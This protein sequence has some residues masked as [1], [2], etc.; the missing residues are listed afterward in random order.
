MKLGII[1]SIFALLLSAH[2]FGQEPMA[3]VSASWRPV[4]Q[5]QQ[6]AELPASGPA[7]A[8]TNDD[9][10]FQRSVRA[11]RT[12]N[13]ENPG[14][15]TIDGRR[16]ALDKIEQQARTPS[17]RSTAGFNYSL[18]VRNNGDK[19]AKVIYWEYQFADPA[20]PTN[21]VRRQF[22]CSVNL[23][24]GGE[25]DLIAFS[26]FGPTDVVTTDTLAKQ[27]EKRFSEKTQVNRIE[28]SDDSILQR[29][30]WKLA[31]VKAGVARATATPWGK[32]I[33]RPL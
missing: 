9:K 22:L 5:K 12:D 21:I 33:C 1:S 17:P 13:P 20:T 23:K 31:D 28:Y 7:R 24:K 15:Q 6:E 8:L 18:R 27:D 10:N 4:V 32:E 29:G 25:I 19:T 14:D 26:T 16:A 2:S 11:S 3:V 30:N